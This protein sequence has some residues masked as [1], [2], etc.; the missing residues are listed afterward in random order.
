MPPRPASDTSLMVPKGS[1]AIA[2]WGSDGRV[3]RLL[4]MHGCPSSIPMF[5]S[6]TMLRVSVLSR[7]GLQ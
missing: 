5:G 4:E 6:P 3:R 2:F 7:T 1:S